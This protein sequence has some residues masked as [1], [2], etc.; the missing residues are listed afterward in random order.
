M[1]KN[2]EGK[3]ILRW[4]YFAS[5]FIIHRLPFT[6]TWLCASSLKLNGRRFINFWAPGGELLQRVWVCSFKSAAR[7]HLRSSYRWIW[8]KQTTKDVP[9]PTAE[10][11]RDGREVSSLQMSF[12]LF[13]NWRDVFST[14]LAKTEMSEILFESALQLN[15]FNY[16]FSLLLQKKKNSHRGM[17]F[18]FYPFLWN[19]AVCWKIWLNKFW[20]NAKWR[21]Q[22]N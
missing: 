18:C 8:S 13:N 22:L 7:Q 2:T 6:V 12:R 14:R 16:T 10:T 11:F 20:F 17:L 9:K 21:F 3:E 1:A 5:K 19:S 4:I 15:N